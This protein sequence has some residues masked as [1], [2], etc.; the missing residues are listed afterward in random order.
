MAWIKRNLYFT[1]TVIVALGVTGY[2]G[3]LLYAALSANAA[4]SEQYA[5]AK[6]GLDELQKKSPYPSPE[7][8]KAAGEDAARVRTF[9]AEFQKPFS[10]FP[11]PPKIVFS[12]G[13]DVDNARTQGGR[14]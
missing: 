6:S 5:Q 9:L 4:A 11:T 1:I 2:C 14:P 13:L 12:S 3:Y 8:I 7:N 10:P